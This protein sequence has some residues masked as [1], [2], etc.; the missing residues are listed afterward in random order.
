MFCVINIL[1]S[2]NDID[3]LY[4][5]RRIE[6]NTNKIGCTN[7]DKFSKCLITTLA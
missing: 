7:G 3:L 4:R 1:Q 6:E 2:C 5:V